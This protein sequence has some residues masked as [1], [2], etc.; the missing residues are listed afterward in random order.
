MVMPDEDMDGMAVAMDDMPCCPQDTPALPD[1]SKGCPLMALCLAKVASGLP[2]NIGLP[3]RVASVAEPA[4]RQSADFE[5]VSPSPSPEPP[6][7]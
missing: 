1:C 2:V 4:W 5:S 6:R 7:S 3:M